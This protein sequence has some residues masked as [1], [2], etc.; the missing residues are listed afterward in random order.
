MGIINW[1]DL[2]SGAIAA[3]SSA[4]TGIATAVLAI[5]TFRYV[6]VTGHILEESRMIRLDAHKPE[7]AISLHRY[8]TRGDCQATLRIE[9]IGTG[10]ARDVQ[11]LTDLSV[12]IRGN[13]PLEQIGFFK[14][15]ITYF[16]HG[17]QL[18]SYPFGVDLN[19]AP[20][21]ITV[22]YK[23]SAKRKYDRPFQLDFGELEGINIFE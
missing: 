9:N 17:R 19:Q 22:T 16:G 3:I 15:R 5:I 8:K 23:D 12:Q 10:P 2:H 6:R 21:E 14:R 13:T 20:L 7:I 4:I 18:E 11:F 1:L